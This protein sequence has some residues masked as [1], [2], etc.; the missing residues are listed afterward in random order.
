MSIKEKELSN[1]EKLLTIIYEMSAQQKG[2]LNYEDISVSAF[3]KYP[4]AF[5]LRGY[6]KYPDTEHTNKRLYDLRKDGFIKV[7]NKFIT[8]TAKGKTFAKKLIRLESDSSYTLKPS[9]TLSRDIIGEIERIKKT[10]AFQL[11][12]TN[13]KEQLVDTD[14]F[15]YLGTTVRAERADFRARVKTVTDV[16]KTIKKKKGYIPIIELHSYLFERFK[17]TIQIKLSLGYPRRKH[18]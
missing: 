15:A 18:G 5:Q 3:K 17:D 16:M 8:L 11:F 10:D 6:P 9:K 13:K 7:H 4:K 12:V 1:R 2:M 14:F